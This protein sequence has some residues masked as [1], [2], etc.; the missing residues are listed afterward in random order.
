MLFVR[1]TLRGPSGAAQGDDIIADPSDT[2]VGTIKFF[3][4]DHH[5]ARISRLLA[6]DDGL[7]FVDVMIARAYAAVG[8][9]R[10]AAVVFSAEGLVHRGNSFHSRPS[11]WRAGGF[12]S[13]RHNLLPCAL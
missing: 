4:D 6:T 11:S 9:V 1:R 13:P 10:D 2:D 5:V 8:Q 12:L 3:R 7:P